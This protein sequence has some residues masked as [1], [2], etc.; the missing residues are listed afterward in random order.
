MRLRRVFAAA[1]CILCFASVFFVPVHAQTVELENFTYE[2]YDGKATITGCTAKNIYALEI[3]ATI[4]GYPVT[5][6]GEQAFE[7]R[8]DLVRVTIPEGVE[9]IERYAFYECRYLRW[10][11]LP[12]SLITIEK[13]AFCG[14]SSLESIAFGENLKAIE[15][16]AFSYCKKLD[17]YLALPNQLEIIG[18]GAFYNCDSLETVI[19]PDSVKEIGSKAFAMCDRLDYIYI[20]DGIPKIGSKVLYGSLCYYYSNNWYGDVFYCGVYLMEAKR[21]VSGSYTVLGGTTNI[22][23]NAFESCSN[24]T[25]IILPDSLKIIGAHA[26]ESCDGLQSI[27]I[28]SGVTTIE[29]E[30]F[31]WSKNLADIQIPAS[32]THMGQD[33]FGRTAFYNNAANWENGVL[34]AGN[35]LVQCKSSVSGTL[36]VRPGTKTIVGGAMKELKNLKEI[37]LSDT[38]TTIGEKAF[39]GCTGLKSVHFGKEIAQIGT[40]AFGQC[41]ALE[42]ITVSS[43]NEMY[44]AKNNCLIRKQD[45]TL[46]MGCKASQIPQD[47]SV[48]S[49]GPYAFEGCNGFTEL[50]IP[51]T[52]STIEEGAFRDC[53]ALKTV[54]LGNGVQ[55]VGKQ[56]FAECDVLSKINFGQSVH[57]IDD[58]GFAYNHY[59][60]RLDFPANLRYLGEEAFSNGT[61]LVSVSFTEGLVS[62]GKNCFT[63]CENLTSVHLPNSLREIKDGAFYSCEKIADLT[64]GEGVISIGSSA[65]DGCK[66]LTALTIPN[67]VQTIGDA[68][69]YECGN[70][71]QVDLGNVQ[72]IG[73]SAFENCYNLPQIH[74]PASVT[75]LGKQAF[76][77]CT[78]MSQMTVSSQNPYYHSQDNCIIRTEERRLVSGCQNSVIPADGS[79]TVLDSYVFAGCRKLKSIVVPDCVTRINEFAF[80]GCYGLEFMQLPFVGG[81]SG[82]DNYLGYIFG[83]GPSQNDLYV[84]STLKRIVITGGTT[85][86]DSGFSKCKGLQEIILPESVTSIGYGAFSNCSQ[87]QKV[88]VPGALHTIKSADI[89]TGSP[90]AKLYISADQIST[91]EIVE[92]KAIPHNLGGMITFVD[93]QGQKI[94]QTWYFLGGKI[95]APDVPEKPADENYTYE[96][97]WEPAVEYCTGNQTI[98]LRYVA[99]RIGGAMQGDLNGDDKINSLDGLLLMRYLNG[100]DVSIASLETMDVNGDGKVNSLDGLILMRYLNGWN[101]VLG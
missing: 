15:E 26:F 60:T 40:G 36:Q 80:Y 66:A 97:V 38:V 77:W 88:I 95:T 7:E 93:D 64:L 42:S 27:V 20:P 72:K 12:N 25:E 101:V 30:A 48:T 84:P 69:F 34:Y 35:C 89:F 50:T 78:A 53:N 21:T 73:R 43:G 85:V 56:A 33:V 17:S 3:P 32:V 28:P 75:V 29:D 49:I 45:R 68:A 57:T 13:N 79:V 96:I 31:Y 52:I 39:Y 46:V 90:Y 74:I 1:L 8:I 63:F 18:T 14:A 70:L 98:R 16:G 19:L 61:G 4:D 99:H 6:I 76:A 23:D 51:D 58:R 67:S 81:E 11:N 24:L 55:V 9:V 59:L 83:G 86:G 100:W 92:S 71:Q 54:N 65:F 62:I 41:S 87:L 22:A 2:V 10:L 44:C 91:R 47:G 82:Y 94:E 5:R 37:I